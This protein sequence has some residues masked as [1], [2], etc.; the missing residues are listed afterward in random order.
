M[1]ALAIA[2]GA[3]IVAGAALQSSIG[4]GFALVSAPLVFAWL[5]PEEAVGL[6][7]LLAVEVNLMTLATERRR[8]RPLLPQLFAILAWSLPG[9]AAGLYVLRSVDEAVLQVIVTIAVFTS[10]A[11][12][13]VAARGVTGPRH[14]PRWGP[15][16][17]GVAAGAV[18]T[19]TT[20][21]GP[22]IVVLLLGRG[23]SPDQ[24]RDTLTASFLGLGVLGGVAL[25]VSGTE[26]AVPPAAAVAALVPLTAAGHLAGRRVFA[27]LREGAYEPVLT[28]VLI[29]SATAGLLTALL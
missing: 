17:A 28:A 1:T 3:T 11:V 10:L 20:T 5:E 13:H 19:T 15:P 2:A 21:S 12:Q 14:A 22:P 29:A 18:T 27:R 6:L 26:A 25:A 16:A 9:L 8:P 4:F 23:S 7:L 24:I